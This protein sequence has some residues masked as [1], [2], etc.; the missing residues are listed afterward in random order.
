M[1][2]VDHEG[3]TCRHASTLLTSKSTEAV[4]LRTHVRKNVHF[5][6]DGLMDPSKVTGLSSGVTVLAKYKQ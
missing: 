1:V 3:S 4:I 6:G 5:E 2:N